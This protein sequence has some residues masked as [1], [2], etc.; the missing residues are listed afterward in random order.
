M[1]LPPSIF[2][3]TAAVI[4]TAATPIHIAVQ[5]ATVVVIAGVIVQHRA[6][7]PGENYSGDWTLQKVWR[8]KKGGNIELQKTALIKIMKTTTATTI[9]TTTTT[10]KTTTKTTTGER[11]YPLRPLHVTE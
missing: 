6:T 10:T 5:I 11:Q 7:S 8:K 3:V 9:T 1:A 4:V 2:V